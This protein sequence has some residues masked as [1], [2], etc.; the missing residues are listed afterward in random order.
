MDKRTT[1][2]WP[3]SGTRPGITPLLS[4]TAVGHRPGGTPRESQPLGGR[5]FTSHTPAG[6]LRK[7]AGD[8]REPL[9]TYK[10]AVQSSL[11]H[12]TGAGPYTRR[13]TLRRT[14][15]LP[16][17]SVAPRKE[18]VR[19]GPL[20]V[21]SESA[22]RSSSGRVFREGGVLWQV[23]R[24]TRS[25]L[26]ALQRSSHPSPVWVHTGPTCNGVILSGASA[27]WRSGVS[28]PPCQSGVSGPWQVWLPAP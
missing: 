1:V 16:L 26:A 21:D 3:T 17:R 8:R 27:P 12:H 28:P 6:D 24:S 20:P 11:S 19:L 10:S 2:D 22:F 18:P 13:T 4:Q 15:T 23:I 5:R 25:T 14:G 9:L 7:V